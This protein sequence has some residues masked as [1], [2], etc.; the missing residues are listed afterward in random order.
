MKLRLTFIIVVLLLSSACLFPQDKQASDKEQLYPEKTA[1]I[2]AI[3][4][5]VYAAISGKAGQ[6]RNWDQFRMLFVKD[7]KLIA[8]N[9]DKEG[10]ISFWPMSVEQFIEGANP[11]FI[12]NGFFEIG[13]HNVVEEFGNI[14]HVFSTY[15]SR[16]S[17]EDPV[18]FTRGINSFQLYNDGTRWYVVSIY[19]Q[20]ESTDNPIPSK[21]L[22]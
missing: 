21:Y 15:E 4:N 13:T 11:F 19:W 22:N 3:L 5:T 17:A 20:N 16:N 8:V 6:E 2:E 14:A 12:K 1:S 18:P 7:A 9:K 10:K